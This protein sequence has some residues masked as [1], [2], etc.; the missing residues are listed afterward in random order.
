MPDNFD[1]LLWVG[2]EALYLWDRKRGELEPL[3]YPVPAEPVPGLPRHCLLWG[4][5]GQAETGALRRRT[6]AGPLS[7]RRVLLAVPDDA[8]WMERRALEDFVRM[9]CIER[10][11][12]KGLVLRPQGE[13]LGDGQEPYLALNWSCRCVTASLVQGG[14]VLRRRHGALRGAGQDSAEDLAASLGPYPLY[15]P[16]LEA[17]PPGFPP[18]IRRSLADLGERALGR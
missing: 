14:R 2:N 7:R 16:G 4:E 18:C 11:G 1:L 5:D 10:R 8:C 6:G 17:P 13:L 12:E 9:A 15:A 3:P